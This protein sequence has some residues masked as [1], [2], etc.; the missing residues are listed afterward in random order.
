[1][2]KLLGL[3]LVVFLVGTLS[4]PALA[5]ALPGAAAGLEE[6]GTLDYIN[7]GDG[8]IVVGDVSYIFTA[9]TTVVL[10]NGNIAPITSLKTGMRLGITIAPVTNGHANVITR[11][12][13]LP[14]DY[15]P[16]KDE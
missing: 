10:A 14:K 5:A 9:A 6:V 15:M 13:V 12:W 16:P 11:I 4:P 8:K 3:S 2:K 1:M 7:P